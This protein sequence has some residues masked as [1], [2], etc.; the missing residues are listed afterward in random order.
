MMRLANAANV[1]V[2]SYLAISSKGYAV[3]WQGDLMIAERGDNQFIAEGP[4]ELLGLIALAE[5]RGENWQANDAE[6]DDFLKNFG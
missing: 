2:R 3:Q 6:I 4:L 1:M 5:T